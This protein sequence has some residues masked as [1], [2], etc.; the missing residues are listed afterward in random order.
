MGIAM[1]SMDIRI[2]YYILFMVER[3]KTYSKIYEIVRKAF[4]FLGRKM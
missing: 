1:V 2:N 3:A 4:D